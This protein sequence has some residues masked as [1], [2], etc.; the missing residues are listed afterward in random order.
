MLYREIIAVCSEIH[1]KHIN[2]LCG[3][4]VELLN[5]TLG[6]TYSN[7]LRL[8]CY[9][10]QLRHPVEGPAVT[11]FTL[12]AL[13]NNRPLP[14]ECVRRL[15]TSEA[16]IFFKPYS[17]LFTRNFILRCGVD[18]LHLHRSHKCHVNI[19]LSSSLRQCVTGT[20]YCKVIAPPTI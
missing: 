13:Y 18:V 12:P 7:R 15:Q 5:V 3:Q 4:N 6:G 11:P 17:L 19:L 9:R 16:A 14:R 8:K 1:T 10:P 2:T 20:A